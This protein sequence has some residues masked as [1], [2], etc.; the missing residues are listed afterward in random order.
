[1]TADKLGC[2]VD[3]DIR[4][5]LDGTNQIRRSEGVI[6]NQRQA[7]LVS[8]FCQ[9][10]DIRNVAVGI[11]QGFN[12]NSP[13]VILNRVF[14][15][16]KIMDIYKAGS[17]AEIGQRMLQQIIAAAV[18]GLLGNKMT[19]VLSQCLQNIVNG[20]SAG[21]NSQRCN[22]A[23]Q[24]GNSLFKYLLGGIGKPSVDIAGI[25]KAKSGSGMGAVMEHIRCGGINRNSPRIG[26][27]I[28]GF[29]TYMEL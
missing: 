29:L 18:D 8:K 16:S 4:T 2:G 9:F 15:L 14:Y 27:G 7:M 21:R 11:A 28:S 22:T 5:V 3:Y 17:D 13:G 6:H 19:A 1:M 20:S 26:S 23:F 10:V 24:S 12:I 25:R